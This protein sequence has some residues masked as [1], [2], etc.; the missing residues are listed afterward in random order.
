MMSD[1]DIRYCN[2]LKSK[3]LDCE[4]EFLNL[5]GDNNINRVSFSNFINMLSSNVF[6]SNIKK[7]CNIKTIL[8]TYNV[9]V[10]EFVYNNIYIYFCLK[11]N[12]EPT[13][14]RFLMMVNIDRD[15]FNI[16]AKNPSDKRFGFVKMVKANSEQALADS[17]LNG[18]LMAYAQLKCWHGWTET[19]QQIQV[20]GTGTTATPEQ[21]AEK[22]AGSQ[23]PALIPQDIVS[24]Q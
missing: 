19:P 12:I 14:N 10:L 8:D 18:N 13:Q 15:T 24:E 5:I 4:K 7:F 22:Y 2:E 1:E 20:V 6:R 21:I 11:Y 23:K 17:M 9:D 3:C 16:W